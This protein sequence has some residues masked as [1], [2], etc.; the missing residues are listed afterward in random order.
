MQI[1]YK[2]I[3]GFFV[4]CIFFIFGF[5][6]EDKKE[7]KELL[8]LLNESENNIESIKSNNVEMDSL[9]VA[10]DKVNQEIDESIKDLNVYLAYKDD[11]L[12][13]EKD[14]VVKV[15]RIGK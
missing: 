3:F 2:G 15:I 8:A 5:N 1:I 9:I 4:L 13:T 12:V 10:T 7:D 6:D 11:F 14:T